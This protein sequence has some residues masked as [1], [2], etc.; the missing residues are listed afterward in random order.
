MNYLSIKVA[1]RFR[2]EYPEKSARKKCEKK[3]LEKY[4]RKTAGKMPGKA[5]QFYNILRIQTY[6]PNSTK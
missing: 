4:M 2:L 3:Y 1:S 6:N 5:F